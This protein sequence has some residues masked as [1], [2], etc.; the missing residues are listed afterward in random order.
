MHWL[1]RLAGIVIV[2]AFLYWVAYLLFWYVLP[3]ALLVLGIR[4]AI[5]K[6]RQPPATP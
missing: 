1:I 4:W 6:G 2:L 5:R 3:F